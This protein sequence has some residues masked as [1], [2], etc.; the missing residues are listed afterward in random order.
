[1]SQKPVLDVF[2]L[3]RFPQERIVLQIDHAET[4]IIASAPVG[5]DLSQSIG[6]EGRS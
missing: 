5:M 3:K 4:Q 6:S 1:M 2:R